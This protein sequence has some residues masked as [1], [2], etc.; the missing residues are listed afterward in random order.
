MTRS[1]TNPYYD[2][3]RSAGEE[4]S[5]TFEGRHVLVEESYLVHPYHS[6]GLVDKGDP[7]AFFDGVGIALKSATSN[8]EV[9]PIDTEGIWRLSV[10]NTG[11]N[12][13][14]DIT[15]GQVLYIDATGVVYDE[16]STSFAVYGYALEPIDDPGQGDPIT[17]VIA[18]KVHWMWPWWYY[19][20][21]APPWG[22]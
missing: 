5:S 13:F 8:T 16:W 3:Y 15:V 22:E 19:T 7:V 12:T 4:I 10:T 9:I 21:T 6:D 14:G 20:N 2:L 1:I 17:Q 11:I 18:V